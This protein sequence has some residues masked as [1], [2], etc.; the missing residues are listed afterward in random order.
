VH[1]Q[2]GQRGA[3]SVGK[4]AQPRLGVR[5]QQLSREAA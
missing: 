2:V 3:L 1:R 5:R 4:A